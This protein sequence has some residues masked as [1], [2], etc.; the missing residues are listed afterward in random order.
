MQT[1][2]GAQL[3]GPL[4]GSDRRTLYHSGLVLLLV[5][6]AHSQLTA[7]DR[8]TASQ[9]CPNIILLFV[10]D[11]GWRDLGYRNETFE[12]PAI[13]R[14]AAESVDFQRAYVPNPACSPSRAALLTGLHPVRLGLLRHIPTTAKAGKSPGKAAGDVSG[15]DD[16]PGFDVHGRTSQQWAR[17]PSDPSGMRSRNWLPLEETTYAE[18]LAPLGYTSHFV[19]KWHLGHEPFHPVK[20]GFDTQYG[21]TNFGHPKSYNAPFFLNSDVLQNVREGHLTDVLTDHVVDLIS[22]HDGRQPFML[23]L[24]YYGVHRPPVGR[25][26]LVRHFERQG[27]TGQQAIYR[28]QVKAVDESVGRIR[29]ALAS[30]GLAKNTVVL[31]TSDQGSLYSNAPLRGNKRVDTLCE[32]GA[33]VPLLIHYPDVFEP[34]RCDVA[35]QTTDIYPTLVELAGGQLAADRPLDG[36]SLLP[37]LH[38]GTLSRTEPLIGYRS[39]Q[40]LYASVRQGPWNL[41]AYRSGQVRLYNTFSDIGEQHDVSAQQPQRVESMLTS[42]VNWERQM[43]VEEFSG[44]PRRVADAG[45]AT[46]THLFGAQLFRRRLEKLDPTREQLAKFDALGRKYKQEMMALRK[47]A[48]ISREDI[49]LRDKVYRTLSQSNLEGDAFW[50]QLQQDG[51]FT[52]AQRMGFEESKRRA[53]QFKQDAMKLLTKDQRRQWGSTKP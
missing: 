32:G 34:G 10:D 46:F 19:G 17:L 26:D 2:G 38:G 21:T 48:G 27:H 11:L 49:K 1:A 20:Q 33:R 39:Y 42:L 43:G 3:S 41:L 8:N 18:T 50:R 30:R 15:G 5:L 14:L 52:D 4:T 53:R 22:R 40:D 12:T 31:L 16:G 51:N 9:S 29:A 35:V 6:A 24:W 25:A 45:K 36:V 44:F 7:A 28:A 47:E 37:V 23:S 13:D